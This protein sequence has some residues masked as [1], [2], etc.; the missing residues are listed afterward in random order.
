MMAIGKQ[1]VVVSA[2]FVYF[3]SM[4]I[5]VFKKETKRNS[6]IYFYLE[7]FRKS[8]GGIVTCLV[9]LVTLIFHRQINHSDNIVITGK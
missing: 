4:L 2:F 9:D 6:R 1:C 3:S 5:L 7:N 8:S